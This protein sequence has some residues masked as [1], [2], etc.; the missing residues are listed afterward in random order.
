MCSWFAERSE[1]KASV[2]LKGF[3]KAHFK[4]TDV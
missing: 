2:G 4:Y 1:M 3:G